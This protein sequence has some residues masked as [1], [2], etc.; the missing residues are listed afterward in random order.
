MPERGIP[1]ESRAPDGVRTPRPFASLSRRRAFPMP[2]TRGTMALEARRAPAGPG[3]TGERSAGP[4][5]YHRPSLFGFVGNVQTGAFSTAIP[6]SCHPKQV[7]RKTS[8]TESP[9]RQ[10]AAASSPARWIQQ[11]SRPVP[12]VRRRLRSRPRGV[13]RS[14][15]LVPDR[16]PSGRPAAFPRPESFHLDLDAALRRVHARHAPEE[17]CR[18]LRRFDKL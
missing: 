7:E 13:L 1:S 9:S 15:G 6:W 3:P 8:C 14:D 11:P 5:P 12:P 2:G 18:R 16:R 4:F 10:T 17:R